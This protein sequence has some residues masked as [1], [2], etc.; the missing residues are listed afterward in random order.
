[1]VQSAKIFIIGG[2]AIGFSLAVHLKSA[3]KDVTVLQVRDKEFEASSLPIM[4]KSSDDSIFK[5]EIDCAS[6]ASTEK[7][8]GLWWSRPKQT[9]IDYVAEA[10][11]ENASSIDL[12]VMQNGIGV[13]RPFLQKDFRSISRC[14]VY[15]TAEKIATGQY[16]ARMVKPSPIGTVSGD[17]EAKRNIAITL[18]SKELLFDEEGDIDREIWKKGIINAVFNQSVLCSKLTTEF[19][20]EIHQFL[21]WPGN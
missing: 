18:S 5:Q 4:V 16:A 8:T 2:G 12:L 7:L 13:E 14:V 3:G 19:L 11:S 17:V 21:R 6:L 9:R 15:I 1:M 20:I 10:L